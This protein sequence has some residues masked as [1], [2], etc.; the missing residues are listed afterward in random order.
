MVTALTAT[1]NLLGSHRAARGSTV[2]VVLGGTPTSDLDEAAHRLGPTAS[3][4]A[5][6]GWPIVGLS[7][8]GAS[9]Q[10]TRFL[11]TVSKGSGGESIP[12]S[13]PEGFISLSDLIFKEGAKG[14]LDPVNETL[15]PSDSV[16][17]YS[18][19]IPPGTRR[20]EAHILQ[21]RQ[22]RLLPAEQP[23]G[24]GDIEWRPV[25]LLCDRGAARG[26]VAPDGP[27]PG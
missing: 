16:V 10:V 7:L 17:S 27:G 26:D 12:L 18:I 23:N 21:G 2:Y 14:L 22:L 20:S 9:P 6:N 24:A 3:L 5:E 15:L 8:P 13:V 1:F 4:F 19:G 25:R 11:D